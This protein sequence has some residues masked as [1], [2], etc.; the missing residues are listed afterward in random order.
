MSSV[1]ASA[2]SLPC[3]SSSSQLALGSS[4]H[5]S[6][7]L[8]MSFVFARR[9][10]HS[11]IL[12]LF[13]YAK[14]EYVSVRA[15][16]SKI[17]Y[18]RYVSSSIGFYHIQLYVYNVGLVSCKFSLFHYKEDLSPGRIVF[19]VFCTFSGLLYLLGWLR[20]PAVEHRSLAGVLSLSCARLVA[21]G[22]PLM[23]VNHPLWVNQLGQLSLSSFRGR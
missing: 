2:S 13:T 21:D 17:E 23:W 10:C 7:I 22:W 1:S 12:F 9:Y 15:Y 16:L 11:R 18:V 4:Q 14:I 20:S 6:R 3:W 19:A 8:S 5:T